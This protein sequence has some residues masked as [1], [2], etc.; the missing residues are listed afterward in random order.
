MFGLH[1][2]E[3]GV[4]RTHGLFMMCEDIIKPDFIIAEV[5]SYAGVSGEVLALYCKELYCIDTS[6]FIF[7]I[8]IYFP[9]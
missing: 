1:D 3:G 6:I 2:D 8:L 5:G 4:N 7:F 9:N